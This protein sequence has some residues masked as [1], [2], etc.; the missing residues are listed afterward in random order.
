MNGSMDSDDGQSQMQHDADNCMIDLPASSSFSL[1]P[2][3]GIKVPYGDL[4][5]KYK[6][7]KG[8]DI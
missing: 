3:G 4:K 5:D 1:P 2:G 6:R 7:R 8:S